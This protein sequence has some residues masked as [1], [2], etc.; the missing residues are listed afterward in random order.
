MRNGTYRKTP[1]CYCRTP[2]SHSD[3]GNCMFGGVKGKVCG[4][5][6]DLFGVPGK[7]IPGTSRIVCPVCK[8]KQQQVIIPDVVLGVNQPDPKGWKEGD[9]SVEVQE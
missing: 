7:L 3:C 2:H 5:C 8:A 4:Q 1:P 9:C 6:R